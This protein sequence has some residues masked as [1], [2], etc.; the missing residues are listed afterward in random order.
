MSHDQNVK[1]Y[2]EQTEKGFDESIAEVTTTELGVSP[3]FPR[4]G[5]S[6]GKFSDPK[7]ET[8]V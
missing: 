8:R 4:P 6:R 7:P 1:M 2:Q 3:G 5:F